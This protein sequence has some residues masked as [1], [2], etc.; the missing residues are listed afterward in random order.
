MGMAR[1]PMRCFGSGIS[2]SCFSPRSA[3]GPRTGC[4]SGPA[5]VLRAELRDGIAAELTEYPVDFAAQNGERTLHA[6]LAPRGQAVQRGAADHD[7]LRTE[8]ECLDDVGTAAEAA[9]DENGETLADRARDLRQHIDRCDTGVELPPAV[10]TQHDAVA[11]QCR[12]AFGVRHAQHPFDEESAAPQLPDPGDVIPADGRIEQRWNHRAAAERGGGGWGQE[13]LEIA[14]ARHAVAAENLEEPA[15]VTQYV[16]RGAEG[17]LAG[18]PIAALV[19]FTVAEHVG[20]GCEHQRL[21]TRRRGAL[22]DV[23]RDATV[24]QNIEL[25]PQPSAGAAGD[26]LQ[27]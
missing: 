19:P 14:E 5:H 13:S 26:V 17:G 7:R 24:L 22:H 15:R 4:G 23:A 16:E 18:G 1:T 21:V 12:G 10:I 8:R 11:T 2:R 20:V 25:H 9:V 3:S 27:T 6:R